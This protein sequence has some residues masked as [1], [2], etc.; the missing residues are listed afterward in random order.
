MTKKTLSAFLL[1]AVVAQNIFLSSCSTDVDLLEE[2]KPI[3]VVYGLLN[4]NEGIQ[5]IKVNKAF[6]GEGNALIMAQQS[7][8]SNYQPGDIDVYLQKSGDPNLIQCFDTTGIPKDD[9]IFSNDYQ[10]LF[11]TNTTLDPGGTYNLIINR[12]T[13]GVAITASTPIVKDLTIQQPSS[14]TAQ[15]SLA[16]TAS[17]FI[18]WQ[19]GA[20][21]KVFNVV[22]RFPYTEYTLSPAD[23]QSKYVDWNLGNV[24]AAG[25]NGNESMSLEIEGENLFKFLSS[26]IPYDANRI[27]AFSDT[28]KVELIFSAG[29][30]D[31]YT[32]IQVNE[33]SI[34]LI[35]EKPVFTNISNGVGIFSSRWKKSYFNRLNPATRDSLRNGRFTGNRFN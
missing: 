1:T 19:S 31:F 12:H 33:P 30:E 15:L 6:L 5:Y 35:Q 4:K 21:G 9:G 27:R 17:Y 23:T 24:V 10:L 26:T 14:P 2:Y 22:F 16:T 32:Y 3:T 34:G 18:R 11:Y 20:N 29:A 8:S 28:D 25:A 13:D 7:D